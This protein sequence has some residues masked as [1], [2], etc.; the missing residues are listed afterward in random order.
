MSWAQ[1][2]QP[3]PLQPPQ[4]TAPQTPPQTITQ[5]LGQGMP[6]RWNPG[7]S[8]EI[9]GNLKNGSTLQSRGKMNHHPSEAQP[10]V[11]PHVPPSPPSPPPL[12][13]CLEQLPNLD[14]GCAYMCAGQYTTSMCRR[15][16]MP[17]YMCDELKLECLQGC[18][19]DQ[20]VD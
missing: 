12:P 14:P 9:E 1:A 16:R 6:E 7:V 19:I 4:P 8:K 5:D 10:H 17:E 3:A 20:R 15:M 11:L 18:A 2:P 13:T